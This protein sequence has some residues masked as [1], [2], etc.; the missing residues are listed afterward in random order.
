MTAETADLPP[1]PHW[2]PTVEVGEPFDL[3]LTVRDRFGNTVTDY[4]GTVGTDLWQ[5]TD[6]GQFLPPYT[7]QP[8]DQG[9]HE[10]TGVSIASPGEWNLVSFDTGDPRIAGTFTIATGAQIRGNKWNDR[11]GNGVLDNGESGLAGWTIYLDLDGNGDLEP[12]EPTSVT[13]AGGAYAFTG[14]D[15]GWYTV[16]EV[17]QPGW[18]QTGPAEG[19]HFV[20]FSG[21]FVATGKDFFNRDCHPTAMLVNPVNRSVVPVQSFIF[22]Y[23]DIEFSDPGYDLDPATILD[24]GPE[25]TLTGAAA[26]NATVFGAPEPVRGKP[27]VYRYTFTGGLGEGRVGINFLGGTFADVAGNWNLPDSTSCSFTTVRSVFIGDSGVTEGNNWG[28]RIVTFPVTLSSRSSKPIRVWYTTVA[29]TAKPGKDYVAKTGKLDFPAGTLGPQYVRIQVICD[30]MDEDDETFTVKLY[31]PTNVVI[32]PLGGAGTIR[33]DDPAPTMTIN[34]VVVSEAAAA[35][36]VTVRL[37]APCGRPVSVQYATANGTATAGADYRAKA[38]T[39]S[40]VPNPTTGATATTQTIR[41]PIINDALDEPRETF[42][43][44]LLPPC[45]VAIGR[46]SA[47]VTIL[48]NDPPPTI[49]IRDVAVQ[50]GNAGIGYAVFTV[51]LSAPGGLPINVRYATANVTALAGSDYRATSGTLT[52]APGATTRTVSV[53]IFGDTARESNE[54]FRVTLS[55]PTNSTLARAAAIGTI[56]NDDPALV[57]TVR[58]SLKAKSVGPV[59]DQAIL[60][61]VLGANVAPK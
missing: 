48:D 43:I 15:P 45:N 35:A 42:K 34:D 38:G 19:M 3:R 20:A 36:L 13:D 10:F 7:F 17:L 1:Q 61:L 23:I 30:R 6:Q 57:R 46:A 14:L 31:N 25:F 49:S 53:A 40:F 12:N 55:G 16:R 54:T 60:D 58:Q 50:E 9:V 5:A 27:N 51:F 22:P 29:G 33:D 44:R 56:L 32:T 59:V 41:V 47:T 8:W 11:N 26:R 39:V 52:F 37:S 21:G 28:T 2:A 18:Q 24:T 4:A